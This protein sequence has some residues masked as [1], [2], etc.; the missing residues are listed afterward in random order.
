MFL[1]GYPHVERTSTGIHD[2]LYATA[3]CLDDGANRI[4]SVA[5][6]V[7][8]VDAI[9]V[10]ACRE[11]IQTATGVP[12]HHVLISATHTHSGP[13]TVDRLLSRGDPVV[14]ATDPEYMAQ[15][16]QGIADAACQAFETLESAELAVTAATVD[17]VGC[18]RLSPDHARD[19]EVGIVVVR[20]QDDRI[21]M[22][23]QLFY[24]MHPTV[25]HE[26]SKLVSSDFPHYARLGIT[27]KFPGARV[28]YHNGPCGNLSPRYHVKGQTFEEAERLGRRLGDFVTDAI[29]RLRDSD[30]ARDLPVAGASAKVELVPRCFASVVEAEAGLREARET[31][32]RLKR[33]DAGH[34]P[35]RT[36]EC[37]VFGAEKMVTMARA[38]ED[39]RLAAVQ[40]ARRSAEVQVLRIGETMLA[41]LSGECF[42]EYALDLKARAGR[43]VFVAS[44]ANG[45]LQGY[46]TTPEARGYEANSSMFRPESGT[47]MVNTALDLIDGFGK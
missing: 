12:P 18:N 5:V 7:L 21:L 8:Y 24:S 33:E 26:D 9:L 29:G 20:R 47:I 45:E 28:V 39:G 3:L 4:I 27:E 35:V 6:D 46:I 36:A 38:Q 32:E 16:T 41:G 23:V 37:V 34:G 40:E 1:W 2:P 42:V 22:G 15:L 44:M 19:P 17:G 43:R 14:D 10:A 11:R 31:Y 13:V 30:Y 25:L